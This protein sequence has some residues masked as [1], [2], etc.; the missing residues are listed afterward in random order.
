MSKQARPKGQKCARGPK[1]MQN[2]L[3]LLPDKPL[4]TPADKT[5]PIT[6]VVSGLVISLRQHP[7]ADSLL[8][9]EVNIGEET[10][11]IVVESVLGSGEFGVGDIVP[12]CKTGSRMPDG[13]KIRAERFRGEWS[14]GRMMSFNEFGVQVRG[15]RENHVV[16]LQLDSAGLN[17]SMNDVVAAA[18]SREYL[19]V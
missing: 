16:R 6:G 8:I 15:G 9:S 7:N 2:V 10:L 13:T 5:Y 18:S 1:K 3:V 14:R 11:Q 17:V 4:M 19:P 12:I